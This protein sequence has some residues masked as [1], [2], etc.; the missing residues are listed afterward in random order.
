MGA[1]STKSTRFQVEDGDEHG[2]FPSSR[3]LSL[4]VASPPCCVRVLRPAAATIHTDGTRARAGRWAWLDL[5]H[6]FT[7]ILCRLLPDLSAIL[8]I[9]NQVSP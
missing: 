7:G 8:E 1:K 6:Y 9:V 4:S 3:P 5:P 2:R